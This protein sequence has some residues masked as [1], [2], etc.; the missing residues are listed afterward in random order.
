M[1][2]SMPPGAGSAGQMP[3]TPGAPGGAGVPGGPEVPGTSGALRR[4]AHV[5][6]LL[7]CLVLFGVELAWAVRDI[8]AEGLHDTL[9]SWLRLND[10]STSDTFL[11]TGAIDLVLLL[12]LAG[13]LI[14]AR[15]ATVTWGYATAGIFALAYRLP[16]LWIFTADWTKGA[17]MRGRALAT[18]IVFVV[19]GAAL[20]L[21]ALAGRR[22]MTSTGAGGPAPAAAP[23]APASGSPPAPA[24]PAAPAAGAAVAGGLLLIVLAVLLVGWEVFFVRK[25]SDPGYPPHLYKHLLTGETTITSYLAAPAAYGAWAT[26]AVALGTAVAAFRRSPLARPLGVALGF[27]AF[28]DG[29]VLLDAWHSAK[30]LFKTD[31]MP[32]WQIADQVSTIVQ[33]VIGLLVMLLLAQRGTARPAPGSV[34]GQRPGWG[35]AAQAPGWGAPPPAGV[36]GY[37]PAA[38]GAPAPVSPSSPLTPP[39]PGT[40]PSQPSQPPQSPQTSWPAQPP[41][42]PPAPPASPAPPESPAASP[43]RSPQ[44]PGAGGGAFGPAPNLPPQLPLRPPPGTPPA[45]APG[46]RPADD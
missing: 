38:G 41:Q 24:S 33:A 16:G 20:I 36:Y 2:P 28:A 27:L 5:A 31:G 35:P 4:P 40:Q 29:V 17:P 21:I 32:H 8:H 10:F 44:Q 18:A 34:P 37:P 7:I 46:E 1:Q 22:G 42:A 13:V 3:G 14:A 25:Y 12:V 15:R 43:Y 19:G 30:M 45:A 9:W 39:A 6:G 11:T 23:G 26:A